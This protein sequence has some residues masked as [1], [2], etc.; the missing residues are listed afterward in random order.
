MQEIKQ[1]L[2]QVSGGRTLRQVAIDTGV[3][4][5][6]L[7]RQ[8]RESTVTPENVVR[9]ARHYRRSPLGGLVA[10]GLLTPD[11]VCRVDPDVAMASLDSEALLREMIPRVKAGDVA[12]TRPLDDILRCSRSQLR[13]L[14]Q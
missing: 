12:L 10:I 14:H 5:P 13:S 7:S 2:D 6:T 9:V 1:W 4:I 11:E 3:S 8:V